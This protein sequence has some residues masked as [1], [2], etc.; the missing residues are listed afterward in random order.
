MIERGNALK[1]YVRYEVQPRSPI[2]II[3]YHFFNHPKIWRHWHEYLEIIYLVHGSVTLKIDGKVFEAKSGDILVFNNFEVHESVSLSKDNEY[4]V[5]VVPPEYFQ[6]SETAESFSYNSVIRNDVDCRNCIRKAAALVDTPHDSSQFLL[7]SEIFKF[8]FA[9]TQKHVHKI[10][11]SQSKE[12]EAKL[13]VS[14]IQKRI[15]RCYAEAINID[16]LAK[17][18]CISVSYLQHTFKTQT[19]HSIIDYLNR[20]RIDNAS[21]L[22][23]ETVLHISEIAEKVGF[24]DYNY[25]SRVFKKYKNQTPTEYRKNDMSIP[26]TDSLIYSE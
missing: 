18:F 14:D 19:G 5:F 21:K 2:K 22:L 15:S 20:T 17:A 4:Y 1:K 3:T 7:N 12:I 16:L 23:R 10:N 6:T 9:A 11:T 26:L 8:L 13:I 24:T 25:F